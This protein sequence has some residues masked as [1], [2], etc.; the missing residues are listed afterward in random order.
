MKKLTVIIIEDG[1]PRIAFAKY[2]PGGFALAEAIEELTVTERADITERHA[3]RKS[4]AL[5]PARDAVIFPLAPK[6][7]ID[8]RTLGP[9]DATRAK[10]SA[11]KKQYWAARR[12][13]RRGAR[14]P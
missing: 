13:E 4:F 2:A 6:T 1:E 7:K 12:A 8:R 5:P 3:F 14:Q 11:A 10:M 9:S